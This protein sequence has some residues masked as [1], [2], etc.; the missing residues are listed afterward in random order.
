MRI[1]RW[2]FL[3]IC[4]WRLIPPALVLMNVSFL[5]EL[6]NML[7]EVRSRWVGKGE[8][9]QLWYRQRVGSFSVIIL[10]WD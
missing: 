9:V 6:T 3:V 10:D 8:I 2:I 7:V 5:A 1:L 4:F